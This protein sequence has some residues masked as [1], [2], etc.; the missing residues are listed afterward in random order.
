MSDELNKI[1]GQIPAAYLDTNLLDAG[2]ASVVNNEVSLT[3]PYPAKTVGAIAAAKIKEQAE[4]SVTVTN[5]IVAR[6]VQGGVEPIPQVRNIIAVS[7]AKGGVGKS[8]VAANLALALHAEGAKAGLLDA[9]IYG[10]SQ[11]VLLGGDKAEVTAA[12]LLKPH[13]LHGIQVLSMGH[14]VDTDQAIVWRGPMIVKALRQLLRETAWNDLDYLVIDLPPGTGD[15]QLSIAQSVPVTGAIIVTTPQS[16]AVADA[17]RGI[18]MFAKV[19]IPVIGYVA[20]MAVFTCPDCGKQHEIFGSTQT[21]SEQLGIP[22]LAQLPLDP[23]LGSQATDG[24]P[25]LAH[26]P[27]SKLSEIF[28]Q[29]AS[30]VGAEISKKSPDRSA[31]FGKI[32]AGS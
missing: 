3:Y 25:L 14:L 28:C 32:V 29:L 24:T 15:I 20:N 2:I 26:D 4:V 1:L 23:I 11:P 18:G 5:K 7:S 31:A 9:D 22:A 21:L 12:G 27:T 30:Q 10:P 8:M 6:T 17:V 16:L 19:S 13:D